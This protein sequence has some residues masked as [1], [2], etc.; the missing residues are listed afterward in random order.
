M[1]NAWGQGR[2]ASKAG[3]GCSHPP[4]LVEDINQGGR[5]SVLLPAS[6]SWLLLSVPSDRQDP[7]TNRQ[8][9]ETRR[10]HSSAPCRLPDGTAAGAAPWYYPLFLGHHRDGESH[11]LGSLGGRVTKV[12]LA[13]PT[14]PRPVCS[15]GSGPLDLRRLP[16]LFRAILKQPKLPSAVLDVLG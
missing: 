13:P 5:C 1:W 9:L 7:G 11:P 3:T 6:I 14:R 4:L 10:L 2:G 12:T 15:V 16:L 8:M